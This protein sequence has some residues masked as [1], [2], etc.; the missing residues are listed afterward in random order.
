MLRRLLFSML[1][2]NRFRTQNLYVRNLLPIFTLP[3]CCRKSRR[4]FHPIHE[5]S[6]D[7]LR[8][9]NHQV[10]CPSRWIWLRDR[11]HPG[12]FQL[13]GQAQGHSNVVLW[14]LGLLSNRKQGNS[15]KYPWISKGDLR[16]L[17]PDGH[18]PH[19]R[20]NLCLENLIKLQSCW[21]F[22]KKEQHIRPHR[23]PLSYSAIIIMTTSTYFPSRNTRTSTASPTRRL[24]RMFSNC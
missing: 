3:L 18:V 15:G 2:N 13:P 5:F 23:Q 17:Y 7:L 8:R 1:K 9:D 12:R 24:R 10:M 19:C 16:F 14:P 6:I 20:E 11:V 21:V 22:L 4:L